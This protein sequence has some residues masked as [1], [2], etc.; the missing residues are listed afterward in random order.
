M[1]NLRESRWSTPGVS[2]A[3]LLGIGSLALLMFCWWFVP[4][5]QAQ[6]FP[7]RHDDNFYSR[8]VFKVTLSPDLG[9]PLGGRTFVVIVG[10]FTCVGVSDAH[11]QAQP[12]TFVS[13]QLGNGTI[14]TGS[15]AGGVSDND[16]GQFPADFNTGLGVD[17]VHTEI[18]DMVLDNGAGWAIRAG[19]DAPARPRS[20]GEVEA[21]GGASGFGGPGADSFFNLFFEVDLPGG[22]TLV[23][24]A[25]LVLEARGLSA[26]PPV[27]NDYLHSFDIPGP[28]LLYD[29]GAS[30]CGPVGWLDQGT[31]GVNTGP[32]VPGVPSLR[33]LGP[34][35]S[36]VFSV[37]EDS[38]AAEG[39]EVPNVCHPGPND[40]YALGWA[41]P[42]PTTWGYSTEGELFQSSGATLGGKPDVTNVD[43]ISAALGIGPAP[44]GGPPYVGPFS[45]NTGAPNPT[46]APPGALQGTLG[47]QPGDDIISVSFGRDGGNVLL[48]SVDPAAVGAAGTAV[49]YASTT[50]PQTPAL[51][52]FGGVPSNGGGDPG[53]EA[54][55]DIYYSPQ[56]TL[57]GGGTVL[58]GIPPAPA[59]SN[60]LALDEIDLGL[61]APAVRHSSLGAP[62]DD[63]D[64]LEAD[65]AARV[66]ANT[67]GRIDSG[68]YVFFT[69]SPT[70]PSITP[71]TANNIYVSTGP[72]PFAFGPYAVG[73]T[74]IG[75]LAGDVID[76]LV[77]YDNGPLGTGAPD[78]IVNTGDEALFSLA[79]GSPSLGAGA[80]PAMPGAGPFSPG[81]VFYTSFNPLSIGMYAGYSSLGLLFAD[82]LDALD[83]GYCCPCLESPFPPGFEDDDGD[84]VPDICDNCPGVYNPVDP[85]YGEQLDS[86]GDDLGNVC[87]NLPFCYNPSQDPEACYC[88]DNVRDADEECDGADDDACGGYGCG[89]DC[90]CLGAVAMRGLTA[91]QRAGAIVVEW[92]YLLLDANNAGFN[93]YRS[94]DES[95]DY[96]LLNTDGLLQGR[97]PFEYVDGEVEVGQTYWYKV[98]AVDLSGNEEIF[99]PVSCSLGLGSVPKYELLWCYP[100]PA[101]GSTT[102]IYRM[103]VAGWAELS[104]YDAA[105]RL[106]KGLVET[107]K[108]PGTHQV[109]WDGRDN[110]GRAVSA[111]TYY[112]KLRIGRWENSKKVTMV[113]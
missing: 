58:L 98:G 9:P 93:L 78:G 36:V 76:A 101:K 15:P 80:N 56:V 2:V 37:A 95:G 82:E 53:A 14:C 104:I 69:L 106:V 62:E 71:L 66:D 13:S 7:A 38:T 84:D 102:I 18:L 92:S 91:T 83:I 67:D 86:D 109:V 52:I 63:L 27:G 41:G 28:V 99:G 20:L 81:D 5:A 4:S 8:G 17:E 97:N 89:C 6:A 49:R 51:D 90:E 54:A 30:V 23:N 25:P 32:E 85:Y 60:S 40:V 42:P 64:A 72:T 12:P 57:F 11:T 59:S 108:G 10:G 77:L 16:I 107:E 87:D 94:L 105:G 50:S 24:Y 43:R 79:A 47:L 88:G 48:F 44:G 110:D 61:Q 70:S 103:R 21:R 1:K 33:Y 112:Y 73:L 45:P 75:L 39:L 65:D 111:G 26:F 55:G 3:R 68:K 46:P 31:H 22:M 96:D 74:N 35:F 34:I 19:R 113:R 29:M 100:N